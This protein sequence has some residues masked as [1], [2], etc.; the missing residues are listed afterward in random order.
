MLLRNVF[1]RNVSVQL[2]V[3]TIRPVLKALHLKKKKIP[4]LQN[5]HS[6]NILNIDN[7]LYFTFDA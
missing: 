6:N 5:V 2:S 1:N 3:E 4:T 7:Y